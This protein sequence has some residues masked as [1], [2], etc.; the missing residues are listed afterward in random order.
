MASSPKKAKSIKY[1]G[2]T[3]F[4]VEYPSGKMAWRGRWRD[5]ETGERK[6][7][8]MDTLGKTSK[9]KRREWAKDLSEKI[10]RRK[11]E[12]AT[13]ME[14]QFES[15]PIDAAV[16][17]FLATKRNEGRAEK[18]VAFYQLGIQ[19]FEEWSKAGGVKKTAQLTPAKLERFR[20]F[21]QGL[22]KKRAKKGGNRGSQTG[23]GT[24]LSPV[25]RNRYLA[26]VRVVLHKWRRLSYLP[27]LN[28]DSI[29]DGL[30]AI[31][32]EQPL[33]TFLKSR[34]LR[35]LLEAAQRHDAE[36]FKI[37][38]KEHDG[39]KDIGTT[40]R[41]API[42]PFVLT[43]LLTGGRAS[44]IREL[45]WAEVDLGAK[46][47]SLEAGRVKTRKERRVPLDITPSVTDF[48]AA[49]RLRSAGTKYV[50]G[51]DVAMTENSLKSARRRL[52]E[53]YGAP[54]FDW[55]KLRR[56]CGTF[57]TCAPGLYVA[58]SAYLSAK[59]LGHSVVIAE[60]NYVGV[61]TDLDPNAKTLEAVMG[62]EDL[63]EEIAGSQGQ[64][65]DTGRA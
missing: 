34:D 11:V 57:L 59:R 36:K 20:D 35:K 13:G 9:E 37:T 40:P 62:V 42:A 14:S 58:S 52:M 16:K 26:A 24:K 6:Y 46:D 56:T 63:C 15:K 49:Q 27:K 30:R 7:A 29:K 5:P 21:V 3:L 61:L 19:Y 17:E 8:T 48:L 38:R 23:A 18:T 4:Q 2:V 41:Y 54:K 12:L 25:S 47:I 28:S 51:G 45:A 55:K 53:K 64:A 39:E 31:P 10:Q 60:R 22:E 33:P 50:F 32:E 1:P 44:E 65:R 43:L